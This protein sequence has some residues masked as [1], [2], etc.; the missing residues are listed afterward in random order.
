MN[1]V[2]GIAALAALLLARF[3]WHSFSFLPSLPE[4]VTYGF[5]FAS[6]AIASLLFHVTRVPVEQSGFVFRLSRMSVEVTPECSGVHSVVAM[7][8]LAVPLGFLCFTGWK[9]VAFIAG[10]AAIMLIKNGVRIA[11]LAL[12]ANYQDARWL[13]TLH[14]PGGL[15][16][17]ALGMVMVGIL[18]VGLRKGHGA[19]ER[20]SVTSERVKSAC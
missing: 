19:T 18:Y 13:S 12:L 5:Q 4:R 15:A 2:K 6:T 1:L 11:A 14:H 10:S 8:I 7:L 3:A 17:F 9:R 16:F 20:D